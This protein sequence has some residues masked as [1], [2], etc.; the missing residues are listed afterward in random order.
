MLGVR[1]VVGLG[2]GIRLCE[3]RSSHVL[4]FGFLNRFPDCGANELGSLGFGSHA[5]ERAKS[6]LVD[7]DQQ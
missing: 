4:L 6:W 7:L 3:V 2:Q 1:P 5:I